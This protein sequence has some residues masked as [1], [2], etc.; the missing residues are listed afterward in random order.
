MRAMP[1]VLWLRRPMADTK[2]AN[3]NNESKT[4]VFILLHPL[5]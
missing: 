5:S 3:G 4:K 1:F 2:A